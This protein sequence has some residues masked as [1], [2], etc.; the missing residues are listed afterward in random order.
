MLERLDAG[1]DVI[2]FPPSV[3]RWPELASVPWIADRS[4][5]RVVVR[6]DDTIHPA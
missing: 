2:D 6:A 4:V 3:R 5:S 1:E